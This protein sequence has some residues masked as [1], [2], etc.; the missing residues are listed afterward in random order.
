MGRAGARR[1][2]GRWFGREG[3]LSLVEIVVGLA[4]LVIALGGIYAVVTQAIRSFG[5]S[6]DFLEVQQNARVGLG[7]VGEEAKWAQ[8][9]QVSTAACP[10]GSLDPACLSLQIPP[11]NPLRNPPTGYQ[12]SFRWNNTAQ[13]L[14]RVEGGTT[15]PL[16]DYVTGVT[17][18]YL[19]AD[20]LDTIVPANVVRVIAE[21][22]VQRGDTSTR[23][24]GSDVF[25]RNAVPTPGPPRPPTPPPATTPPPT[26]VRSPGIVTPTATRTA[27]VTPT[28][29]PTPAP[30][31]TATRTAP[32][33]PT[34]TA[35]RTATVTPTWTPTP[36]PTVTATV[37]PTVTP[38]PR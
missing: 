15:T 28:W 1:E 13:Q 32:P 33:A 27:T 3:G 17:F 10:S 35:T 38:R 23:V 9:A 29:T 5:V 11:D 21:I 20:G 4:I 7:K 22:Q 19:G 6:E 31:V 24:V 14:E 26:S 36:A 25:L 16:A 18:R 37:T 8:A 34:V 2:G 12:V 30:T